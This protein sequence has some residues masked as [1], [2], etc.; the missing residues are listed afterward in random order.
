MK[1]EGKEGQVAKAWA[2]GAG[3]HV[4]PDGG[5]NRYYTATKDPRSVQMYTHDRSKAACPNRTILVVVLALAPVQSGRAEGLGGGGLRGCGVFFSEMIEWQY[6][7][8]LD[9]I[10]QY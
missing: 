5:L 7:E 1:E 10:Q 3:Y 2:K 6:S 8:Q 4:D 9:G